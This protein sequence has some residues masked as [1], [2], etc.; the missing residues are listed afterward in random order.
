MLVF[1][2]LWWLGLYLSDRALAWYMRGPGFD[3]ITE[4]KSRPLYY[5]SVPF[6]TLSFSVCVHVC[7][8]RLEVTFHIFLTTHLIFNF[9]FFLPVLGIEPRTC[10]TRARQHSTTVQRSQYLTLVFETMPLDKL[11]VH[12]FS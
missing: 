4:R 2:L 6:P 9:F 1:C 5:S 12:Q 11:E 3:P 7:V 8:H 10:L